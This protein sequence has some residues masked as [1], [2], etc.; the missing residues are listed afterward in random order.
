MNSVRQQA[1]RV[2]E[3][4]PNTPDEAAQVLNSITQPTAL[5]DF[6]AANMQ[7]DV[8]ETQKMLEELDLQAR[9]I[10]LGE[11]A[12]EL[13]YNTGLLLQ[14][15]GQTEDAIRLY[16]EAINEKP[17]FAEALLNL[18][19]ALKAKGQQEEANDCWKQALKAK[20]E[21]AHGYFGSTE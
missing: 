21:L 14:K 5:A 3:L 6:V 1:N 20:P 15:T 4:S 13:F 9:L 11:H 2:I 18:G 16:K 17:G 19:H 10:E 8:A 12:P 7:A